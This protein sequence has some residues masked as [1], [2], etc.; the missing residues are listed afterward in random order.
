MNHAKVLFDQIIKKGESAIDGFIDDR[1]SESLF[2]DF[3]RAT[4]N[5]AGKK[6]DQN[7]RKNLAKAISGFGNS[8]GGLIV[9]GVDCREGDDYAD[10][11]RAKFPIEDAKK[12]ESWL[13]GAISSCTIPPHQKVKHHTILNKDNKTGY[14]I[15]FIPKSNHAPHQV[16]S[17]GKG[18]YQ[19]FI[20]TGSDFT[21][22]PH[23]VLSGMFGRRPQPSVFIMYGMSLP[24]VIDAS[25]PKLRVELGLQVA[26]GG[27]GIASDVFM[28][29][30]IVESPG[31]GCSLQIQPQ[32]TT[33]WM[34]WNAFGVKFTA[35]SNKDIRLPPDAIL[36]PMAL[37]FTIS[38]PFKGNLIIEGICG[39]GQAETFSFTMGN[40]SKKL[41]ELY[42]KYF[43]VI[44]T[45]TL[46]NDETTHKAFDFWNLAELSELA[47][48]TYEKNN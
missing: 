47:K 35:I 1:E 15:T 45:T 4:N 37:I 28:N 12:F 23:A 26:N 32:D 7:D 41:E 40:D 6:L 8:E 39:C 18:Q 13:E 11:A 36:Q 38:P 19:Y 25:S 30:N 34:M 27:M 2:L 20:R 3:K 31:G 29:I 43:E 24:E 14:V 46:E 21:P 33:N 48:Q 44:K 17:A 10:V 16:I 5:G 42:Y 22:T 9:W